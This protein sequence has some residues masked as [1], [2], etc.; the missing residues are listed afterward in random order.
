LG[1]SGLIQADEGGLMSKRTRLI[2][3]MAAFLTV[4]GGTSVWLMETLDA[5]SV[6]LPAET[7]DLSNASTVEVKDASGTV[8]LNGHF[9]DVPEDDDDLERKAELKGSGASAAATGQAEVEVSKENNRLDQEV[10]VSVSNLAPGA[11][12]ALFIDGKQ[13]G[14]FQTNKNGRGELELSTPAVKAP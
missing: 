4:G 6:A 11:T 13:L 3:M 12:Y 2:L 10:E 14:T 7:G 1:F 5:Q 9:V 8:V